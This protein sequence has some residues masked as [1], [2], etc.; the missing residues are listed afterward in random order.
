[1]NEIEKAVKDN[2]AKI[3]LP[4]ILKLFIMVAIGSIVYNHFDLGNKYY[5][6][7]KLQTIDL[8]VDKTPIY[9]DGGKGGTDR[10]SLISKES[11]SRLWICRGAL[12]VVLSDAKIENDLKK[13]VH[14][15]KITIHIYEQ[16]AEVLKNGDQEVS[17]IGLTI[18]EK[19]IISPAQ[20]ME[21]DAKDQRLNLILGAIA[22]I[23]TLIGLNWK[24]LKKLV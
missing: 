6:G 8:T 3:M 13:I 10:F 5:Q 16:D 15:Q 9:V 18:G 4:F 20:T 19:E 21:A 1:M 24:T 23:G 12:T 2:E 17:I 11:K 14:G 22:I 7:E